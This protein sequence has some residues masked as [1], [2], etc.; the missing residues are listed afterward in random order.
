MLGYGSDA[1]TLLRNL[2]AVSEILVPQGWKLDRL[3]CDIVTRSAHFCGHIMDKNGVMFKPP[4]FEVLT[5]IETPKTCSTLM[6]LVQGASR[7]AL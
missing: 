3:K 6:E 7:I 4:D 5:S 1:Q 2:R